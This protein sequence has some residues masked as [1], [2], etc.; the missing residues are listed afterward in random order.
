MDA[1]TDLLMFLGSTVCHQL[2]E[3]SY[4][5]GDVQMPLCARCIGIHFGFVLS[6]AFLLL[7][8]KRLAS[9]LPS[10][11]QLVVLG[12]IMLF[13]F[14]DAGLSYSGVSQSDNLRRTLSGLSLGVPLPFV[15]VS[16]FGLLT[17]SHAPHIGVFDKPSDWLALP[18]LF[19]IGVGAILAA[20]ENGI[21][22]YA[23][24]LVGVVG[25]FVFFS[26]VFSVVSVVV[27]DKS[28]IEVRSKVLMA[29]AMAFLVLM[30]L[31]GIHRAF[32]AG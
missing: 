26:T 6:A 30:A 3:R 12:A 1:F 11:K 8:P 24:S 10:T 4:F 32:L 9:K 5:Y 25:V 7:G 17:R 19:A 31:A 23:V 2:A 21:L 20:P 15:L 14:L 27:L 28:P 22:F 13:Y 16:I 29:T 18:A